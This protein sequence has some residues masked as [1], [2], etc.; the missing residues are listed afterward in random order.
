VD[1]DAALRWVNAA[2]AAHAGHSLR[3]PEIV[4][5]KGT[6][7]GL[8]YEQMAN[9]SEYSTNYL[10]RDVAPKLWKQL[11]SVFARSVGKTNFRVALEAYTVANASMES[12]L[13]SMAMAEDRLAE[14]TDRNWSG[15]AQ[16][17][18]R[19][20]L[21]T[22]VAAARQAS[23][24][25]WMLEGEGVW[26]TARA[27]L[28]SASAITPSVMYGYEDDLTQLTQWLGEAA[29]VEGHSRLIGVWGLQ[30]IGKTLL[31]E[32]AISAMGDC[33]EGIVWRSLHD[34]PT[35]N[36]LS[37]S[38]LKSLG[39]SAPAGQAIAQLLSVLASRPLL[40]VLEGAEALLKTA[41]LAG[42]YVS[43]YQ[44]YA[45]FFQ[46]VITSRSCV[47]LTGIEGPSDWV[48]QGGYDGNRNVRSLTLSGLSHEDASALLGAE[49]LRVSER[50]T[51]LIDRYQGHPLALKSAARVIREIFNGRVDAF[52]T[53][54]S[55]L[56]N[57]IFRLLSPSFD[58]LSSSE[59]NILYWLASYEWPLSLAELQ[60]TLPLTLRPAELISALDSLKQRSLLLVGVQS[61]PPTFCLPALV[62]AYAVH[63]F[64][65]Q[66]SN[67]SRMASSAR[68]S[69]T[70]APLTQVINLSP[71]R[72]RPVE[73]SQWF[74]GQFEESW[75]S[76]DWLFES[77]SQ[78]AMR[79]R[80]AY[81]LRDETFL[82]RCKAIVFG[83][84]TDRLSAI[85]LVAVHQEADQ[86]FKVCV[87]AQPSKGE[88]SLPRQMD[89]R[90]LDGQRSV[91]A[92]VSAE[93][94]DTFIQ[95]PYFRGETTETFEIELALADNVHTEIFVI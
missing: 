61:D 24:R 84:A 85:L 67:A 40:L 81:H 82:K 38:I 22:D 3:E 23:D 41:N 60:D 14:R 15:A 71:E 77:A 45:E 62:K 46:S 35:L 33:F 32:T 53:Q 52:L 73:L 66:F 76:L 79:L 80:S 17:F 11:S 50:W 94:S 49:Q 30:G 12:E 36:D 6:W 69:A 78:P 57:G 2:M 7:R 59:L 92:T 75:R 64:M 21:N 43:G 18:E 44:S 93:E 19:V 48:R 83:T 13:F 5:L 95:L 65:G 54:S 72:R 31:V 47:L 74:Q 1:L 58:R 8:T 86:A 20:P 55:V 25:G 37:I 42:D 10:M 68:L 63:Q 89:L 26:S 16:S 34:R 39:M 9:D 4:I 88:D 28:L 51:E 27:T 29:G 90:L 91:L 56:F 70:Y 87:Q